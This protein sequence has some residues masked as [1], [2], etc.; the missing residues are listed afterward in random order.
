MGSDIHVT[1]LSPWH[2]WVRGLYKA[3]ERPLEDA[4]TRLEHTVESIEKVKS[5][6]LDLAERIAELQSNLDVIKSKHSALAEARGRLESLIA[7][8]GKPI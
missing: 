5:A 8:N 2:P 7:S 4:R 1:R 3:I 6:E